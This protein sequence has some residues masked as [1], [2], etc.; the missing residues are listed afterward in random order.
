MHSLPPDSSA[1]P[2]GTGTP[3][4]ALNWLPYVEV[5]GST[6]DDLLAR[7]GSLPSYTAL[8][9]GAQSSG[10]GR[11]GR[12][13]ITSGLAMS[14]LLPMPR[15]AT[16]AALV[17]GLA[18]CDVLQSHGYPVGVKWP[19]DVVINVRAARADGGEGVDDL[20]KV[21]GVL[22]QVTGDGRIVLGIGVNLG[23]GKDTNLSAQVAG[24][25]N[26]AGARSLPVA[27]VTRWGANTQI[28]AEI[29]ERVIQ[30][31]SQ[32]D[33]PNLKTAYATACTT[34]GWDVKVFPISG[35]TWAG[36]ASGIGSSGELI[37]TTGGG[38]V[39]VTAGD[40]RHLR[41]ATQ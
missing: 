1:S 17:G 18:V 32:T 6:N 13:W 4:G 37:V 27:E 23:E 3:E 26:G 24:L 31:W 9:A 38:E 28:A 36:R 8:A 41:L 22:A 11:Q 2:S 20:R 7:A 39:M 40:I 34:L 15:Q 33:S 5:T 30:L 19:N 25:S 12:S 21:A 29:A 35:N 10:H 14:L 16:W